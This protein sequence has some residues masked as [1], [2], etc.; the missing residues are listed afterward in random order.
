MLAPVHSSGMSDEDNRGAQRLRA[1][2]AERGAQARL[3]E[4]TGIPQC[5]LS[6]IARGQLPGRQ[7]AAALLE[8]LGI[9][10]TAWDEPAKPE[11][12]AA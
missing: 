10:L 5:T 7:H 11:Q 1:L 3:S 2:L 8:A 9:E 6:R 4:S 12:G